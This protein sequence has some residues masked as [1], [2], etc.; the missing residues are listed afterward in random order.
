MT[1]PMT[2]GVS[3]TLRLI[4]IR[5]T[6]TFTDNLSLQSSRRSSESARNSKTTERIAGL[7]LIVED[8]TERQER[9]GTVPASSRGRKSE[10]AEAHFFSE[11]T[12]F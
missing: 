8:A 10:E 6:F 1:S 12:R 7:E 2:S 9:F 11:F 5:D 4:N 3:V